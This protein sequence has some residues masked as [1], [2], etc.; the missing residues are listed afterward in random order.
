MGNYRATAKI[1]FDRDDS[2]FESR[3]LYP[4]D[5]VHTHASEHYE[6]GTHE[7]PAASTKVL[8]LAAWSTIDDLMVRIVSPDGSAAKIAWKPSGASGTVEL[9]ATAPIWMKLGP[10]DPAGDLT[11]YGSPITAVVYEIVIAGDK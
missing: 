4:P 10:V 11:L 9:Q 5:W 1:E 7:G 6:H 2:S 3:D 8:D